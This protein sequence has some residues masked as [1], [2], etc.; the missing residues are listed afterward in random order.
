M[1]STVKNRF[2]PV[3]LL[4]AITDFAANIRVVS[5]VPRDSVQILVEFVQI[6]PS[7]KSYAMFYL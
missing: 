4:Y 7:P 3:V 2:S 5:M 6:C 1:A